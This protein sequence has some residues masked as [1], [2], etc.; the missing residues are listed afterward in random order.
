MMALAV[1]AGAIL[2]SSA[3]AAETNA[4]PAKPAFTQRVFASPEEAIKVLQT[5]TRAN[6]RGTL[7]EIFGPE[8]QQLSTGDEVQDANNTRQV[9]A[10]M[11]QSCNPVKDGDDKIVLEVGTNGWPMPIPLVR[12]DGQWHFD[13]AAG[14]EEVINRHIG[15]DELQAIGVCRAFVD[16]QRRFADASP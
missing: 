14:K 2:T 15:K 10:A 7:R 1:G 8:F 3:D 4:A 13:T 12:A 11:E 16:A 6:D 9:G 5:A